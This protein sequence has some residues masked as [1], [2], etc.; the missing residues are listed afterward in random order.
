[1]TAPPRPETNMRVDGFPFTSGLN[2]CGTTSPTNPIAQQTAVADPTEEATPN[3]RSNVVNVNEMDKEEFAAELP[4][5]SQGRQ[6][7]LDVL[8]MEVA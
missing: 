8:G 4:P 6:S 2:K 5:K 3:T 7:K 1:M